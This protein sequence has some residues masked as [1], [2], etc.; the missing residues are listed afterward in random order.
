MAIETRA[1]IKPAFSQRCVHTQREHVVV[2]IIDEIGNIDANSPPR[3]FQT[4][5]DA[6]SD[7]VMEIAEYWSEKT[8]CR[9]PI[10]QLVPLLY[11]NIK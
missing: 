11:L 5:L 7:W 6:L 10:R 8:T 3:I 1:L 2:A 9:E 4:L